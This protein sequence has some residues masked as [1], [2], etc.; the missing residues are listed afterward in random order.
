M[1]KACDIFENPPVDFASIMEVA[2]C[3]CHFEDRLLVVKRHPKKS[4]GGTWGVPGGKLEKNETSIDA[5]VREM[6]EETGIQLI[7]SELKE[8]GTLYIRQTID[9]KYHLFQSKFLECPVLDLNPVEHTE[10]RWVTFEEAFQ[11]P[12]MAGEKETLTYYEKHI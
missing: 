8:I 6:R 7:K 2:A 9:F 5:L 12:L 3:Y 10:A 1:E 11:M 4:Q